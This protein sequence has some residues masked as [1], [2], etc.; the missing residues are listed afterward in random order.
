MELIEFVK[1][2]PSTENFQ[3]KYELKINGPTEIL[4]KKFPRNVHVS[5]DVVLFS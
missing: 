4:D 5:G 2:E 3:L 1:C